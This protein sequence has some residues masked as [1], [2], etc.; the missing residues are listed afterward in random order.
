MNKRLSYLFLCASG[1]L[2]A[3]SDWLPTFDDKPVAPSQ[4]KAIEDALPHEAI[5]APEVSRRILVFSATAGYRHGSIPSGRLAIE[6]M[7]ISSGAYVAVVSDDFK[8][9]EKEALSE[10]DAVVLNNTSRDFFMPHRKQRKE[11]EGKEWRWLQE[12][13][14]R[15]VDNLVEFV[16]NGG[17]LVGIHAASDACYDHPDFGAVIGGF[18][19]GHPWRSRNNVTLVVEDPEH[20][21]NKPVF[22]AMKDFQIQEE[23]YQFRSEPYS[24]E[25]LRILLHLDPKRSD[26]VEG[27][28]REDNDYP[29]AWVQSVGKGRVF[30]TSLGH[31]DHIFAN[32]L[33]LKHFLAGIQFAAGDLDADTTPSAQLN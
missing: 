20:A 7:G 31:N 8:H 24:R 23:I 30:Y 18:F 29:V 33:L 16:E 4:I 2:S 14:D 3:A 26:A 1:L 32:P 13:N 12:R 11:F 9:F 25:K 5:V 15:L 10:F 17:G 21:I 27:M 22:E 19:D 28:K 6:K